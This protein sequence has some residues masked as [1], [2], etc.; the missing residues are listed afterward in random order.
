MKTIW[1]RLTGLRLVNIPNKLYN[2]VE[3]N[4]LEPHLLD[5]NDHANIK[6]KRVNRNT[7]KEVA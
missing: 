7:G 3:E 1:M 2:F 5:K 6:F 4:T